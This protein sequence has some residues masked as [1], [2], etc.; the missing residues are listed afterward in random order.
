[1]FLIFLLFVPFISSRKRVT[2]PKVE[3]TKPKTTFISFLKS[4]EMIAG[5]ITF[6][7]I[8]VPLIA[9]IYGGYKT[10]IKPKED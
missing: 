3:E 4:K 10:S 2:E 6:F 9:V 8:G 1:M 7:L 5:T